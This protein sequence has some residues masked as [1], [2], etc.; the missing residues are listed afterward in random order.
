MPNV[1]PSGSSL[2]SGYCG[3]ASVQSSIDSPHNNLGYPSSPWTPSGGNT[4]YYQQQNSM[5]SSNYQNYQDQDISHIVDQVLSCID[6]FEDENQTSNNENSEIYRDGLETLLCHNCGALMNKNK[7]EN[8]RQCGA[9]I[10][11]E[12]SSPTNQDK[13]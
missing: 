2:D 9:E 10:K 8:C 12:H 5:Q 13:R 3:P 11:A 6:Q 1:S 4:N 7:T